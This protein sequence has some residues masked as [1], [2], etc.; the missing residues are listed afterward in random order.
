[1]NN[2]MNKCPL[3]ESVKF[4]L[5]THKRLDLIRE[6]FEK[7][8]HFLYPLKRE[9][10]IFGSARFLEGHPY[11]EAARA[12][13][14]RLG[15]EGHTVITGGG[16]GI[17]EA[18]NRGAHEAGAPSVGLNIQL[19]KE[20]RVNPYVDPDKS[21]GFHYFF[22]RKVMLA[23]SAQ[24]YIMFPGGFGTMDE[25][26]E[27]ITLIQTNKMRR[28]PIM[29]WGSAFWGP[30]VDW[31]ERQMRDELHTI[32]PDDMNIFQVVDSVEEVMVVVNAMKERAVF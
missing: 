31:I 23:A 25:A 7:G 20:Q 18:A 14:R 30:L 21:I 28:V 24:A 17:M 12:L 16:P 13:A 10:S 8:F 9:V 6:E 19:P 5:E 4:E 15:E 29:L 3:P 2:G 32:S 22:S 27:L 26:F 1:M 11:Y